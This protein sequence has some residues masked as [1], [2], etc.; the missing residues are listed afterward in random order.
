[1]TTGPVPKAVPS[2]DGPY[3]RTRFRLAMM[4]DAAFR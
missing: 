4:G 1:V 3:L 2:L